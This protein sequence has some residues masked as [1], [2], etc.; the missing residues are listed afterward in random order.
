LEQAVGG[1][2]LTPLYAMEEGQYAG[3]L[4]A[5]ALPF[6]DLVQQVRATFAQNEPLL[7]RLQ[8]WEV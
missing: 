8:V 7:M 1:V 4:D 5:I 6:A 2:D 3:A